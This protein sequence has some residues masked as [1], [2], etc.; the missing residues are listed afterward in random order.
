[1]R[2]SAHW[3]ALRV[4]WMDGWREPCVGATLLRLRVAAAGYSVRCGAMDGRGAEIHRA[5][6]SACWYV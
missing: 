1:M 6:V 5:T 2:R 4:E 3:D